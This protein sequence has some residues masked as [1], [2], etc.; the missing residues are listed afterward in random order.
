MNM[1]CQIAGA[2]TSSLT[3]WLALHYGWNSAFVVAAALVFFGG[4]LW[5]LVDPLRP[6][7]VPQ[8]RGH[9]GQVDVGVAAK[10]QSS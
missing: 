7:G 4:M 5:L 10:T 1:G 9:E 3:P 6:H 8:I 2:V